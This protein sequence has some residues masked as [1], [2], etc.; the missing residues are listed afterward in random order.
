[1]SIGATEISGGLSAKEIK[2]A[3]RILGLSSYHRAYTAPAVPNEN[4]GLD[5]GLESTFIYRRKLLDQ[6][7]A[8]AVIPRVIPVPRF[9]AAWDLPQDFQVSASYSPGD[10]F[11]GITALGGAIQYTFLDDDDHRARLSAILGYTY[12]NAF[13]DLRTHITQLGVQATRDL[14]AWQPYVGIG[15]LVGNTTTRNSRE[16]SNVDDGPYTIPAAH[17]FVGGN[18]EAGS[19]KFAFQLDLIGTKFSGSLLIAN[20]F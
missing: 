4:L 15:A 8:K 2:S 6:G 20:R 17:L 14:E 18:I 7:N 13:Q 9:W 16:A 11:D 1:M 5:L 10:F 3:G 19:S 12:T